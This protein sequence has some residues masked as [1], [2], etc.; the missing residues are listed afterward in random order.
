MLAGLVVALAL[1][2]EAIAFSIIAGVDPRLGLFASFTMAVSI[3]FL[4]GRPAMIS[5]AMD[6]W[7]RQMVEH[8]T[9]LVPTLINI[10]NFPGI[11]DA[12]EKFPAY[13]RHMRDLHERCHPRIAAARDA[14]VP[15]YAGTDAGSMVAHGRIA[16]EVGVPGTGPVTEA[17]VAEL[18]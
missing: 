2:P 10:E 18:R 11:A 6:G 7:R 9:A 5:A 14:G 3:A 13:A 4:G 17:L 15:I 16:D 1:I 8:G 12:A